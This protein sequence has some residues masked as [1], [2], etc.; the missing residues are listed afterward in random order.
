MI[1]YSMFARTYI[2]VMQ[3]YLILTYQF[4]KIFKQGYYPQSTYTLNDAYTQTWT[5]LTFPGLLASPGDPESTE[6]LAALLPNSENTDRGK[7][8][9]KTI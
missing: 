6:M 9:S 7:P 1:V 8:M 5:K 3:F 4:S 2:I